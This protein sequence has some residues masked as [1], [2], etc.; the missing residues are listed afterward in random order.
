MLVH[1]SPAPGIIVGNPHEPG[2]AALVEGT[3]PPVARQDRGLRALAAAGAQIL[4]TGVEQLR[5]DAATLVRRQ[6]VAMGELSAAILKIH[7]G[8]GVA[9]DL[10]VHSGDEVAEGLHRPIMGASGEGLDYLAYVPG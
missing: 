10:P 5:T 9:D 1:D 4:E 8:D 6:Y 2:A 3:R 7:P